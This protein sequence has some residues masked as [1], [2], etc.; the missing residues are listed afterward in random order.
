LVGSLG[1]AGIAALGLVA[2]LEP[3]HMRR[4]ATFFD[5]F[6]DTAGSG[7]QVIQGWIALASG[8]WSGRGITGGFAQSGFL[9]EAHTDFIS[10]VVGE[11]FGALGFVALVLSYALLV[12]RGTVIARRAADFFGMLLAMGITLLMGSQAI[13]NLGVVVGVL[14]P[15]GLVLP[16]LSYGSS[17][18][19]VHTLCV[20]LLLRIS[21]HRAPEAR[22]R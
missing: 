7:Y 6:A 14:P 2:V 20:A 4:F 5:P 11:E 18:A 16:F 10:A 8:G 22:T 21:M 1:G 3:Y 17:A 9:P 12:W 19:L 13:I 15:K